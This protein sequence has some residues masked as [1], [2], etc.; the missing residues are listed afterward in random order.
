MALIDKQDK[1]YI[2][3]LIILAIIIIFFYLK[4]ESKK[5]IIEAKDVYI[6]KL[7]NEIN[8]YKTIDSTYVI[9]KDS[10]VYNII[11]LDSTVIKIKERYETQK[12]NILVSSDNELVDKFNEL[13]WAD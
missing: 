3:I 13:V 4:C 2:F 7:E 10:I 9:K 1:A 8:Y 5:R 11:Q 12:D 6:E